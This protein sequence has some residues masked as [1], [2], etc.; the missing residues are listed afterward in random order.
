MS[1]G[2]EAVS[3]GASQR[4]ERKREGKILNAGSRS[5]R[6]QR[7]RRLQETIRMAVRGVRKSQVKPRER[8][9]SAN[10][11][12]AFSLRR[13]RMN[14]LYLQRFS[15]FEGAVEKELQSK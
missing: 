11:V 13:G 4:K 3:V 5:E 9:G 12:F 15:E 8:S 10:D 6:V 14:G 2:S 1:V 7:H